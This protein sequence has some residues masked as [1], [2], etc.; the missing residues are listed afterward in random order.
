MSDARLRELERLARVLRVRAAELA[1]Y[2]Q[3]E[4]DPSGRPTVAAFG[5][6]MIAAVTQPPLELPT[7]VTE[8]SAT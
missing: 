5:R 8:G 1:G 3:D 2:S 6:R 4:L 7:E